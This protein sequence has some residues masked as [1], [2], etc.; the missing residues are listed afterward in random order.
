MMMQPSNGPTTNGPT[1]GNQML[2]NAL[3]VRSMAPIAPSGTDYT[4]LC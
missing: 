2:G 3:Q 4:A 1:F